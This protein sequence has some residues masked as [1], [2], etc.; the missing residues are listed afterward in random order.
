M[1]DETNTTS[2]ISTIGVED[3]TVTEGTITFDIRFWQLH[4]KVENISA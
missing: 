3:V 4:Q 2:R 1:P